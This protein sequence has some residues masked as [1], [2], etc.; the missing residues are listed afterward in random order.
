LSAEIHAE[1][2]R[3]AQAS[4]QEQQRIEAADVIG[5]EEFRQ[6]YLSPQRLVV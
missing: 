6:H 5:F 3:E 2:A 4:V 1:L